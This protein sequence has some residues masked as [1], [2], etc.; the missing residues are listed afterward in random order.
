MQKEKDQLLTKKTM[1]K[2]AVTKSL[3]S[4]SSLAQEEEESVEIQVQKLTE[5]IQ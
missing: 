5:A 3:R 4:M 1:I 2:E